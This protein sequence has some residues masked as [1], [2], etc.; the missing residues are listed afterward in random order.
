MDPNLAGLLGRALG[1]DLEA[2]ALMSHLDH[3][4]LLEAQA[5]A[6]QPLVVTRDAAVAVLRGLLDHRFAPAVVQPWASFI[7]RGYIARPA[8]GLPIQPLEI[9]F[10]ETCEDAISEVVSRLDEIGDVVDGEVT[11]SE[12]LDFLQLLGDP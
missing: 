6:G 7:R 5:A 1:G 8:A 12:I 3:A 4:D 9:E 2:V 11:S 10:D